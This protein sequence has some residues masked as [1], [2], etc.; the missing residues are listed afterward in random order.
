MVAALASE[1]RE[2]IKQTGRAIRFI[3]YTPKTRI[4]KEYNNSR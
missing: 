4:L 1:Q 3:T 2:N